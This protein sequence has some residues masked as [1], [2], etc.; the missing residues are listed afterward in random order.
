[1]TT[2]FR[3]PKKSL[4]QH[5]LVDKNIVAKIIDAAAIREGERTLEIGPGR[6][7]L[8]GELLDAGARVL[9]VEFDKSL[10]Q[11]LR[12]TYGDLKNF[13]LIEA[14]ALKLDFSELA[15]ERGTS[16]K[17]VSNLPYNISGPLLA[18]F[19]EQ[20]Q[21]FTE[22]VLMLQKEVAERLLAPPST[23]EY[24]ALTV[25]TRTF[26]GVER[27]FQVSPGSFRP[28]PKVL[29]TVIRL[30]PLDTPRVEV[31]DPGLYRRVVKAAFGQRR[32]TL[33]NALKA[34][35][36]GPDAPPGAVDEALS[37][38]GIDPGR[39]GETLA[40]EEFSALTKAFLNADARRD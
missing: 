39:R 34:L 18:R 12:E 17:V 30:V 22:L 14:D 5:F 15:E 36:L 21:A 20:R 24:G 4:G 10:A 26:A 25:L 37:R 16:F 6:G 9:A 31:H 1:M 33:A 29:S 7:A 11:R 19:I 27:L 23:K 32:K 38:A 3:W 28:R 13:E 8:T 2:I 35:D 40:L